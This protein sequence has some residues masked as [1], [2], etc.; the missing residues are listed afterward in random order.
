MS[1][2]ASVRLPVISRD[3]AAAVLR[4]ADEIAAAADHVIEVHAVRV[5]DSASN[6]MHVSLRLPDDT[7]FVI[8][9]DNLDDCGGD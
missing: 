3:T 6:A 7:V 4:L 8:V 1:T 9:C 5:A 2:L